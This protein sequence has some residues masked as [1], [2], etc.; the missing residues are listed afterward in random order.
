MPGLVGA[1]RI[2][3][4]KFATVLKLL[5]PGMQYYCHAK[6]DCMLFEVTAVHVLSYMTA[7]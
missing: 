6:N 1:V 3:T 5:L 2:R 4:F 7:K